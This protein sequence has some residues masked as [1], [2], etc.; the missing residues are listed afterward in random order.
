M[1]QESPG[2]VLR[3][4]EVLYRT[5]LGRTSIYAWM[6]EG[7][8]PHSIQLGARAVG[9]LENDIELWINSRIQTGNH[10]LRTSSK[11]VLEQ[12]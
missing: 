8:F 1:I 5:G 6:N 4:K 3:L 7:K 12:N 2:R 9:W 11:D 10:H